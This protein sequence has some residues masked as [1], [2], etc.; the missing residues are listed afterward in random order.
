VC[1][2]ESPEGLKGSTLVVS[3]RCDR[4]AQTPRQK[5]QGGYPKRSSSLDLDASL[6][7]R[8]AMLMHLVL[9]FYSMRWAL[10]WWWAALTDG[11]PE[12]AVPKQSTEGCA[13]R[14]GGV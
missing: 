11:G 9:K 7:K 1:S 13:Q 4:H 5:R 3:H 8:E 10:L 14:G 6:C 12:H 2:E